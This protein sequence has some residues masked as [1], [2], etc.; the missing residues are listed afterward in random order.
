VKNDE[1]EASTSKSKTN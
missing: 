1:Q